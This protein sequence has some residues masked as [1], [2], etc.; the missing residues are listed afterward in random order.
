MV[1]PLVVRPPDTVVVIGVGDVSV[2]NPDSFV[3]G[4]PLTLPAQAVPPHDMGDTGVR[5]QM[6]GVTRYFG[7]EDGALGACG[8]SI[9][10]D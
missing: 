4:L 2:G 5:V 7:H 8:N 1:D 3:L 9:H 10:Q 6:V